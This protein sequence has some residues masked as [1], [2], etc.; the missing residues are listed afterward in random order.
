MRITET[1]FS[2]QSQFLGDND[3]PSLGLHFYKDDRIRMVQYLYER[4]SALSLTKRSDRPKA[5]FG[6]Q[7]R[8]EQR[9][10]SEAR[11]GVLWN[12]MER[13]LLWK[14]HTPGSLEMIVYDPDSYVPSWSW[15]AVYGHIEFMEIPF[16]SVEWTRN[17]QRP[18]TPEMDDVHWD[19]GLQVE[20]SD[21]IVE[22]SELMKIA[23]LDGQHHSPAD[24]T[25][26]CVV[27]GK[28]KASIGEDGA[29][30]YVLLIR[31]ASID[32]LKEVFVRVGVATLLEKHT[33]NETKS[34]Y[35][36]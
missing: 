31:P 23:L 33:S 15:M 13:T 7:K 19:G 28:G 3:F 27:V 22:T 4:Y 5:I 25:W 20:S 12:S 9:F 36:M 21:L 1:F 30:H 24:S 29:A 35:L 8:L 18:T 10:V 16:R 26:R 6:L 34:V 17:I 32:K 14:A 2:P 11:Y